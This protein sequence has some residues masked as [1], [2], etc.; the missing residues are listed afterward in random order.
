MKT[1]QY[2][3]LLLTAVVGLAASGCSSAQ[4]GQRPGYGNQPDYGDSQAG[5][6]NQ[7]GYNQP[8]YTNQPGDGSPDFYSDLAPYGDW[9]QTP[10]YGRV[11]I[12]RAEAGFQPY[13]SNGHWIVTDYGNTWVSDYAWGWAPFHYGRWY[14][15]NYRGWAWV[16]GNDWGPAWVSWRTGGGYYGW[17]P[18]GPGINV[19]GNFN[20]APNFWTFV[21]QIYITSPQLYSYCVPRPRVVNIYQN[22]TVIN[23]IYRNNNRSY[24]YG[25][26]RNEI[27][28][29]TRRS[30][31]VYRI[32][33]QDRPGRYD[34]SNGA[35]RIYRPDVARNNSRG[36]YSR[37]GTVNNQ[38]NRPDYT[39]NGTNRRDNN[40]NG[41]GRGT[42]STPF[43][44]SPPATPNPTDRSGNNRRDNN[45]NGRGA[46]SAPFD[47]RPP[48]TPNSSDP[49]AT[50]RR[51]NNP[52]GSGRGTYSAPFDNRPSTTPS[53]GTQPSRTYPAPNS[54]SRDGAM[55]G[56]PNRGFDE[57][58]SRGTV[59]P[60]PGQPT[61]NTPRQA[62]QTGG[63]GRGSGTDGGQPQRMPENRGGGFSQPR[64]EPVRVQEQPQQQV[65]QG[66]G[67]Y[68]PQPRTQEA[69]PAPQP[70][71][72]QETTSP[73]NGNNG[74]GTRGPR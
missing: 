43:D 39:P 25:P 59:T 51:D 44:N 48:V 69:A 38:P 17:A 45:P 15:D 57:N 18:L 58:R 34:V 54:G 42:Y 1:I 27:E 50:D 12:P 46:Y 13:A 10:E 6:D 30:V 49:S 47:S 20:I 56:P 41:S 68:Q 36:T 71:A 35:V 19:G 31:P 26:N 66:R 62:P 55:P 32:E 22:T 40:P 21:P 2:L 24:Y 16:P 23:N 52:N 29:V 67:S 60:Q 72:R 5:Y 64:Q 65:P 37:P 53:A 63:F 14:R 33:R 73:P 4:Y 3:A 9:V 61:D 8:D 11:W 74:R 7:S 70:G 28:R